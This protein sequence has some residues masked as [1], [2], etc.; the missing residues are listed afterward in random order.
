VQRL[1]VEA[2]VSGDAALLKQ[3]MLMDPLTGAMCTPPEVWQL[4]DEMLIA[5]EQWLPQ[6]KDAISDAKKRLANGL[7]LPRPFEGY[8]GAARKESAGTE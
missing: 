4:T 5:G 7:S 3:A 2:A 8:R 1:A 6:Y